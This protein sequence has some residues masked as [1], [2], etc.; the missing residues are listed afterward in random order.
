MNCFC[1]LF[2]T[3]KK[4]EEDDGHVVNTINLFRKIDTNGDGLIQM[5]EF[6]AANPNLTEEDINYKFRVADKNNDG[7]IDFTEY[8][9]KMPK[10]E[11]KKIFDKMDAN[12]DGYISLS[13]YQA[14]CQ[15]KHPDDGY[16]QG[17]F[18]GVGNKDGLINFDE[19]C[20]MHEKKKKKKLFCPVFL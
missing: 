8:L 6:R 16:V 14:D 2:H 20:K 13:Q 19:F 4:K 11:L 10:L 9:E 7:V 5:E 3:K 1:N 15:R 18:K 12:G 17:L